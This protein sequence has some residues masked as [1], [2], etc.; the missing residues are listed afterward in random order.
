MSQRW[1]VLLGGIM[2]LF[3]LVF[4]A[5]AYHLP[6]VSEGLLDEQGCYVGAY[7][8]GNQGANNALCVNFF[9]K[10]QDFPYETQ[11][12]DQP[13][14]YGEGKDGGLSVIDTGI[15]AF[16]RDLD[17]VQKGSGAKQVL[18]SRYYN[19]NFYPDNDYGK[20]PYTESEAPYVWAEKVIQQGGVP[21]LAF[22]PY[23]LVDRDGKIDL[24]VQN[25][26]RK[27][28]TAV[29][30][31]LATNLKTVT[32]RNRDADGK[33]A[34]VI[35]WFAHEFNTAPSV[36]PEANDRSDSAHKKA[37]RKAF[38]EAYATLHQYGGDGIQVAWA[39]NI[40]KT[41][42]DRMYYW[43]GYDD[44]MNELPTDSV[45]WVGMTWYPW[46]DGPK[47]LDRFQGFYDFYARDR[48]HP[49][50]VMETSAD[51]QGDP[52]LEQS[53]KL[54]QVRYLYNA[55][56]LSGYPNIKGIV[57]FNVV[58][59][60]QKSGSDMMVVTKNFLIPDGQ[61][62]NYGQ[63]TTVPG[64]IQ[65]AS[66]PTKAMLP[67]YPAA[68]MDP[69]FISSAPPT[70]GTPGMVTVDFRADTTSGD[71]PLT[72]KF[73]DQSGGQPILWRYQ[74]GDGT[75][76]TSA[77]PTHTYRLPGTYT[78]TLTLWKLDGTDLVSASTERPG[79]I[80]VTGTPAPELSAGFSA[81]PIVGPTPL[82]VMFTDASTGEPLRYQYSFGDGTSSTSAN[83]THT[84]RVP[85]TYTVS[86]TVLGMT[87]GKLVSDTMVQQNLIV[88]T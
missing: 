77:N 31:D 56:T 44:A 62:K 10:A 21:V 13:K 42:E 35:I 88:V 26:N 72:V 3:C 36:N 5:Q 67:D 43:P 1:G 64:D 82:A 28:G 81:G 58:K 51:G 33:P 4:T 57:W 85:G 16:R 83:P 47:T 73:T 30:E 40:A 39:G 27:T 55:T 69:Y 6:N 15:A 7:L 48:Q 24:S 46:P 70:T 9:K 80:T 11:Y 68:M 20:I 19:M 22:D 66:N 32:E 37:F 53:L 23:A 75:S 8:G 63:S 2:V 78:V 76:S 38:R 50:I 17:L 79:Y 49:F 61:W 87:D 86:L 52:G 29:L 54:S 71:A 59:G 65:S 34:T 60:E 12:L 25:A 84:Y 41:K 14:N 45:D 18:F 74:F